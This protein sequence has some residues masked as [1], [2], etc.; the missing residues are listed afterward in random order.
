MLLYCYRRYWTVYCPPL[1]L[2][3]GCQL[4]R[5]FLISNL[6]L[7]QAILYLTWNLCDETVWIK[8]EQRFY[9][10]T[11]KFTPAEWGRWTVKHSFLLFFLQHLA[12]IPTLS[13]ITTYRSVSTLSFT[14]L[15]LKVMCR[16]DYLALHFFLTVHWKV[17]VVCRDCWSLLV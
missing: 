16:F 8:E 15:C 7:E 11:S 6:T 5:D 9:K 17:C 13:L 2:K 3:I 12:L 4:V 1:L 14:A 10:F